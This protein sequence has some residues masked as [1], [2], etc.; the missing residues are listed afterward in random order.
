MSPVPRRG[1]RVGVPR[2][3][4][5]AEVV[6]TDS[7]LYGGSDVGNGGGL[8]S[9]PVPWHGQPPSVPPTLPPLGGLLLR[10]AGP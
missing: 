9:E 8:R 4:W 2:A 3:G 6:N 5:W 7:A 10:Y 1:Y